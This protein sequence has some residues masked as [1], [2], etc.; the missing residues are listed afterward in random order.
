MKKYISPGSWFAFEYPDKWSEFEDTEDSFL[1][2]NPDKWDGNFR[3]SA[4]RGQNCR[5]AEE[6]VEYELKNTSGARRVKV[7]KWPC[8]YSAENFQENG[9]RYTSHIWVT[10]KDDVCV[11]CSF[12]VPEGESP[13]TAETIV[14]SLQVRG[15]ADKLWGKVMIPVRVMEI[16]RI[17]EGYDRAVSAV[18]KQLA[19]DFTSGKADVAN[20]QK[21]IDGGQFNSGQRQVWEDFGIAFA[22]ILVNEMDGMN[23]VTVVDGQKEYPALRFNDTDVTVFPTRLIWDKVRNGL[24]CNLSKEYDRIRKEAEATLE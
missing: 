4:Y 6:A 9:V 5:Y 21:M 12:V 23:W 7:G 18:K 8:A 1:F 17:N 2:Y 13:K 20:I 10:G 19:K 11:E 3:I 15:T 24:P 14:A 16:S 22:T